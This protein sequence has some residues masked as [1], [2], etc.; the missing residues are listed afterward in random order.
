MRGDDPR[1]KQA[2]KLTTN[3]TNL[4]RRN[5]GQCWERIGNWAEARQLSFQS[6]LPFHA[7]ITRLAKRVQ[8]DNQYFPSCILKGPLAQL[9]YCNDSRL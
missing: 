1:V 6:S 3:V 4:T 2:V 7:H 5:S 9:P 8:E